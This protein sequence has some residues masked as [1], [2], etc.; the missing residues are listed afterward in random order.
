MRHHIHLLAG[1]IGAVVAS[2]GLLCA[3]AHAAAA[4]AASGPAGAHHW[5]H[6]HHVDGCGHNRDAWMHRL[7]ITAQQRA[8]MREIFKKA[9]ADSAAPRA[10]LRD[11]GHQERTLLS[12]PTIDAAALEKLQQQRSDVVARLAEQRMQA[13]IAI[14]QVL[15]PKQR[16]QLAQMWAHRRH[17]HRP[18]MR[19]HREWEHHRPAASASSAK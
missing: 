12:A 18:W 7:G 3:N 13:R 6:D 19:G 16:Q 5:Q 15:T 1:G 9:R 4:P 8:S 14:A 10:K 11:L 2:A 17:G